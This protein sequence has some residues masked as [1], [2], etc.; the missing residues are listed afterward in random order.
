MEEGER[1]LQALRDRRASGETREVTN[2]AYYQWWNGHQ[3]RAVKLM[4]EA[5]WR[6]RLQDEVH[7]FR[8]R[9][10]ERLRWHKRQG[11]D[12]VLISGSF[13]QL[14]E[15]LAVALGSTRTV[16]TELTVSRGRFTG[17]I[18]RPMIGQAKLA[19]L[20]KDAEEHDVDLDESFGYGDHESDFPFLG[21]VGHPTLVAGFVPGAETVSERVEVWE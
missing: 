6:F 20:V 1:F 7:I 11:H 15:P 2:R 5:W 19:A 3:E 13:R 12:V 18:A 16:T 21:R 8:T 14:I 10:L 9:S 4:A 17:E